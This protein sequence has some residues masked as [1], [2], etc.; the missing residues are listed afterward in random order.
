MSN[1]HDDKH[2]RQPSL[3]NDDIVQVVEVIMENRWLNMML[4]FLYFSE[5]L[6][7][8]LQ[9][10]VYTLGSKDTNKIVVECI[11][12]LTQFTEQ[13]GC[14]WAILSSKMRHACHLTPESNQLTGWKYTS[15]PGKKNSSRCLLLENH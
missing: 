1:R 3:V 4:L 15:I 12:F 11:G 2:R 14:C 6:C 5:I 8:L 9:G 7:S 13:W 10:I